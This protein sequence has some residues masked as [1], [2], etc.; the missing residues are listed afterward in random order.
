MLIQGWHLSSGPSETIWSDGWSMLEYHVKPASAIPN[1]CRNSCHAA[2]CAATCLCESRCTMPQVVDGKAQ[3]GQKNWR[4]LCSEFVFCGSLYATQRHPETPICTHTHIFSY[5]FFDLS[6]MPISTLPQQEQMFVQVPGLCCWLPV[7]SV[8]RQAIITVTWQMLGKQAVENWTHASYASG[9]C[10]TLN[11][12]VFP[13]R[14]AHCMSLAYRNRVQLA[15]SFVHMCQQPE[16]RLTCFNAK[17]HKGCGSR[18]D[19]FQTCVA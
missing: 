11:T 13:T 6:S 16:L 12:Q 9:G 8:G 14:L 1:S 10:W 7:P 18:R 3:A 4:A 2:C 5:T 19:C 15:A 17:M